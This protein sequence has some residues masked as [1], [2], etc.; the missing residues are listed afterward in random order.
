MQW[1]DVSFL[2]ALPVNKDTAVWRLITLVENNELTV[3]FVIENN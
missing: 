1:K 3:W 2:I